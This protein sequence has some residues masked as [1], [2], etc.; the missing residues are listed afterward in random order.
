MTGP[1]PLQPLQCGLQEI[2]ALSVPHNVDDFLCTN[3]DLARFLGGGR[4][5]RGTREQ[6]FV[7][8]D[9]G[10]LNLSLYL[11]ADVLAAL[12][13]GSTAPRR[14]GLDDYCLALEGVS[15][16]LYLV[17]YA[18]H[19]RAVTLLEMELQAEID[20]YVM[21]RGVQDGKRTDLLQRLF[22]DATW[23]EALLPAELDRYREASRLAER[24]CRAL[25]RRF[26]SSGSRM[27]LL[28][29]LRTF[30]RRSRAD[31]LHHIRSLEAA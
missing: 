4:P 9:D 5:L 23:H 28:C 8:E 24:Y 27:D 31:K 11:D 14:A 26:I 1:T 19:A 15:H 17:W 3:S 7:R 16:F 22:R 25:D 13:G 29:E 20:K 6:V 30:Y 2:Y 10:E 12:G 18:S 21:L